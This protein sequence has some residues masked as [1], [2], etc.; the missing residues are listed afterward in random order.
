MISAQWPEVRGFASTPERS[1][2]AGRGAFCK[3]ADSPRRSE[4]V[5]TSLRPT[6]LLVL[7]RSQRSKSGGVWHHPLQQPVSRHLGVKADSPRLLP[8]CP[9]PP[10]PGPAA[11][12]GPAERWM[13]GGV[14]LFS[15]PNCS[16]TGGEPRWVCV[17]VANP[18]SFLR[19]IPSLCEEKLQ[20]AEPLGYAFRPDE[21]AAVFLGTA[22]F[23]FVALNG[24]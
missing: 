11:V 24:R 10:P 4:R 18:G 21:V 12:F 17:G 8:G 20:Q 15:D 7:R 23:L 9:P 5:S 16:Q 6:C 14:C 22:V 19:N 3:A 2:S 13:K 1:S